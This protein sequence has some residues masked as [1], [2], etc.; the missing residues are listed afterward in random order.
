M[1]CCSQFLEDLFNC[2]IFGFRWFKECFEEIN[3]SS[4]K[5]LLSSSL[6]INKWFRYSCI[7]LSS[8]QQFSSLLYLFEQLSE[9]SNK[10]CFF[11]SFK[12]EVKAWTFVPIF[13]LYCKFFLL[14]CLQGADVKGLIYCMME[15]H[16]FWWLIFW[17][18]VLSFGSSLTTI[19]T[20]DGLQK[21]SLSMDP[22][23]NRNKVVSRQPVTSKTFIASCFT[24]WLLHPFVLWEEK[25]VVLLSLL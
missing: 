4:L 15:A 13:L 7:C 21:N 10:M 2:F 5:S 25:S 8:S 22:L 23:R 17:V 6:L 3:I 12:T 16:L 24:F 9:A 1:Q 20:F 19:W 11:L 18:S 14:R